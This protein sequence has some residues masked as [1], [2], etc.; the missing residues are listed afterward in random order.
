MFDARQ[1]LISFCP[2]FPAAYEDYPF[3]DIVDDGA[4]NGALLHATRSYRQASGARVRPHTLRCVPEGK[5]L[6]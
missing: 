5:V 6:A 2:T 3:D 1:E 4:L